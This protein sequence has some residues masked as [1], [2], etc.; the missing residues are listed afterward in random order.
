MKDLTTRFSKW[1]LA[2]LGFSSAAACE[3]FDAPV[4]YGAPFCHFDVKCR[5]VNAQ[6]QE[7]VKGIQMTPG[8]V[9]ETTHEDGTT[10][11]QFHPLDEAVT[12][13]DG[14]FRFTGK[15]FMSSGDFSKL[16]LQL[17]DLDPATDGHY[18]DTVYVVPM[19]KI[20]DGEGWNEGTYSADTTLEAEPVKDNE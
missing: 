2:M 5:V 4:E 3:L 15:T 6:T 19:Q 18:K 9:H 11:T 17:K 1:A 7:P 20:K 13:E 12:S 10:S 14:H 8:Y 16:H